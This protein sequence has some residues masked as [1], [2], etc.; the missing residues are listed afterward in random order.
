MPGRGTNVGDVYV[1]VHADNSG[2]ADEVSR[3]M[4]GKGGKAGRTYGD[5]FYKGLKTSL[6]SKMEAEFKQGFM[7]GNFDAYVKNFGHGAEGLNKAMDNINQRLATMRRWGGM[8]RDQLDDLTVTVRRYQQAAEEAF[9]QKDEGKAWEEYARKLDKVSAKMKVTRDGSDSAR[10]STMRLNEELRKMELSEKIV[11]RF[12]KTIFGTDKDSNRLSST[13]GRAFG[14]GSRNNFLNFFGGLVQ[15]GARIGEVL[16]GLPSTIFTALKAIPDFFRLMQANVNAFVGGIFDAWDRVA[17][18]QGAAAKTFAAFGEIGGGL[19]ALGGPIA[20]IITAAVGMAAVFASVGGIILVLGEAVAVLTSMLSLLLGGITAVAG[21][22]GVALVGAIGAALPL[23]L[24]L[25]A[26]FGTVMIA[27]QNMSDATKKQFKPLTDGFKKLGTDIANVFFKDAPKWVKGLGDLMKNFA[28]PLMTGVAEGVRNAITTLMTSLNSAQFKPFLDS[29]VKGLSGIA[30]TLSNA[31]ATALPGI[32]AFFVPLLPIA[33]QLADAIGGVATKF[34]EWATSVKGQKD[35]SDFFTRAWA[36][37][38]DLWGILTNVAGAIGAVLNQGSAQTGEGFLG[39]LSQKTGELK[40]FLE[41]PRGQN[42]LKTWFDDAKRFGEQL[43]DTIQRIGVMLGSLDTPKNREFAT[44]L[45]DDVTKAID[46]IGKMG[47]AFEAVG[48]AIQ[49][50]AILAAPAFAV[51]FVTIS[52]FANVLGGLLGA[53]GKLP[54]QEWATEA[55]AAMEG[56]EQAAYD[57]GQVAINFPKTIKTKFEGDTADLDN[58]KKHADELSKPPPDVLTQFDGDTGQLSVAAQAALIATG[59]VPKTWNTEFDGE[60]SALGQ[61]AIAAQAEVDRVH[62][63]NITNFKGQDSTLNQAVVKANSAIGGVE[64]LHTTTFDGN[65]SPLLAKIANAKAQVAG[66]LASYSG[67]FMAGDLGGSGL[68]AG[69]A[70]GGRAG[71]GSSLAL[72]PQLRIIGEDGPE[73]V[74][75][76][77]RSLARVDSS[78]RGLSAYAQGLDQP[79]TKPGVTIADGAIRVMIPNADPKL[80]AEAVLDR[81]VGLLA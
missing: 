69:W 73:A 14:K 53:W 11:E 44:N 56:V 20:Q 49:E 70:G 23:V 68:V 51:L 75:P 63:E 37:A 4:R 18:A 57:A 55:A 78:V 64:T 8:T 61:A 26:A 40:A 1:R 76:L 5:E 71:G 25:G 16:A 62:D 17:Q 81:L 33:K 30:T 28:G 66:L 2:F 6:K 43:W 54:G 60:H 7:S 32:I 34:T 48:R 52:S 72:G 15:G 67:A 59:T 79:A 42:D 58:A 12:R 9:R 35:I 29:L 38:K 13:I 24:A 65:T 36:A 80:A 10:V 47:P 77:R 21:A 27:F 74:V 3:G 41:S 45:I 46:F 39:W 31:F 22:L 50:M 19:A